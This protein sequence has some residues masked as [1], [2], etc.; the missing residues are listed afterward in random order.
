MTDTTSTST[1]VTQPLRLVA[2][3]K[4]EWEIVDIY[5][6][7]SDD[8][9]D[10]VLRIGHS[11]AVSDGGFDY[12]RSTLEQANFE[13]ELDALRELR[14]MPADERKSAIQVLRDL[15][16]KAEQEVAEPAVN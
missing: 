11:M 8:S 13:P 1:P 5:R 7:M 10:A 15:L 12:Q 6:R 16:A 3:T 4:N 14:L 2:L 9:K